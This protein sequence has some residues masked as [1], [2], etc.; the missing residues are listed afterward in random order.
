MTGSASTWTSTVA[1]KNPRPA[2]LDTRHLASHARHAIFDRLKYAAPQALIAVEREAGAVMLRLNSGSN[3]L[4]VESYLRGR[5]YRAE[6]A[7]TNPGGY[8]CSVKVTVAGAK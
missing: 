2:R 8:G 4:A 5:G 6:F 3:A 1:T 7:G